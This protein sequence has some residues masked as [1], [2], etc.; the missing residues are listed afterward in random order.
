MSLIAKKPEAIMHI[1]NVCPRCKTKGLYWRKGISDGFSGDA[2]DYE[3]KP[4]SNYCCPNCGPLDF[5]RDKLVK[6]EQYTNWVAFRETI[7]SAPARIK[8]FFRSIE[9]DFTH[10]YARIYNIWN[11]RVCIQCHQKYIYYK[12]ENTKQLC[13]NCFQPSIGD[14]GP[15]FE[16][17]SDQDSFNEDAY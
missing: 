10:I 6:M 1:T 15:D 11:R 4:T 17:D 7:Y 13:D 9:I 16:W 2:E 5:K 14:E 3:G 12:E 8:S